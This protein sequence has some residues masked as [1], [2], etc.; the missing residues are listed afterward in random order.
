LDVVEKVIPSLRKMFL[1][2]SVPS[3]KEVTRKLPDRNK[4]FIKEI[5]HGTDIT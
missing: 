2:R 3:R 1:Q 5:L 4:D